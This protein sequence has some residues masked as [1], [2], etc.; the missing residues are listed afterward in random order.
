L[1]QPDKEF[2]RASHY[3]SY[4]SELRKQ[5]AER[6]RTAV[7]P[8]FA[9]EITPTAVIGARA[10]ATCD[11][12]ELLSTRTLPAGALVSS[13]VTENILQREVVKEAA[14]KVLEAIGAQGRDITVIVP[15]ASCRIALLDFDTLP[16]RKEEAQAVVRFRLKKALPFDAEKAV[17]SYH[18]VKDTK[19]VRV[20][21]AIMLDSV[22]KDY[23][24][25]FV[26]L[27]CNPGVVLPL[28]VS[29]LALIDASEPTL[30]LK[31]DSLS[32]SIAV[33]QEDQLLLYRTLEHAGKTTLTAEQLADD[34]YPSVV[35][36]ADNF[37]MNV[38]RLVIAGLPDF[39]Q[40]APLLQ[41][42]TGLPVQEM[43]LAGVPEDTQSK[44]ELF[45][46]AGALLG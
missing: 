16:E 41:Q 12:V 8:M 39:A 29:A 34:I 42:H 23:E 19:G 43:I 45:A 30:A 40:I 46:V 7:G 1:K 5:M 2:S 20:A 25:L 38:E 37:S 28:T 22:L 14:G 15:D 44:S 10:S 35:Y 17:I 9:C 4:G 21:V 26:E 18:Q 13:L 24:S 11:A 6:K 27:G 31:V 3:N 33:L 36:F 32:S